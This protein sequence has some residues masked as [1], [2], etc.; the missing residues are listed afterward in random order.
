MNY[1]LGRQLALLQMY[2]L[3]AFSK[4]LQS[5]S[6]IIHIHLIHGYRYSAHYLIHFGLL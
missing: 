1:H 4:H 3:G 2:P 6:R 5:R